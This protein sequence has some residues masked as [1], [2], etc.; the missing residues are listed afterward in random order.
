MSKNILGESTSP[1]LIQHKDNPVHWQ[2][3]GAEALAMAKAKD[4]PILLSV[5]YAACHWCHVMAHESFEDDETAKLMNQLF[6]NIKVD[7]E[8]RPDIDT[9]YMSAL[10]MLGQRGGWP[11]TMFLTPDGDP[12]W[13][14]T[15]FPKEPRYGMPSFKEVLTQIHNAYRTSPQNIRK[16]TEA[17]RNGLEQEARKETPGQLSSQI[18]DAAAE[19]LITMIDMEL[20]GLK[21]AP[22]FPQTALL[23]L[24]WRA[25]LRT[26]NETYRA[27]VEI[28]LNAMCQG[29]IY[30]HLGGGWA[31]YSV[32]ERWLAPHFEKM[33][34]D[35][36]LLIQLLTQVWRHNQSPLYEQRIAETVDWLKREMIASNGGFAASLDA[37]SE[38]EEGKFYVWS[39]AELDRL[40]PAESQTLF[41]QTYDVSDGGNWEDTNILN[42]LLS[43]LPLTDAE[44]D[45][46]HACRQ[47]LLEHRSHR[48]RPGWDD[49]VLADWNGLMISA[50]TSAGMAFDR[51]DWVDLART[52]YEAVCS[53][54]GFT[55]DGE[56]RL[57]HS[58]RDGQAQ[59]SA[60]SEDHANMAHAA[61]LLFEATQESQY[62]KKAEA[63]V[64]TLNTHY[65]A[66]DAGG[67]YLTADDAEALI[68]RT[69]TADDDATPNANGTMV[70]VLT[71]LGHIT[72]NA[73]YAV[74][75]D[76]ILHSFGGAVQ[77]NF[78]QLGTLLNNFEF[79]TSTAQIVICGNKDDDQ[80]QTFLRTVHGFSIPN[81][82]LLLIPPGTQVPDHHPATGK[83][84]IDGM[85]TAY[86]C[87]GQTCSLPCTDVASLTDNLECNFK[88]KA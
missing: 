64:E 63:W 40:L 85:P 45:S 8:E 19:K 6:V 55:K 34:Y 70:D 88:Q 72:G 29:G 75:A 2:V 66:G 87:I 14:G 52:A 69:R 77:T 38:G 61:L 36:A 57:Y 79:Y 30:D 21:G 46:L 24:L 43:P 53:T 58:A 9:I 82:L 60:T 27:G 80:V 15:Y 62:L 22:K 33:L 23:E 48:E 35:N 65:W 51:D 11:L 13:G 42:R 39:K 44:E 74:R 20:G 76:T 81:Q 7:R 56:E 84:M 3:W 73:S 5:G 71:R 50:L 18:L 16:N 12:F 25:Y 17:L 4:K 83:G 47:L 1:Y 31:R 67:Y 32:D 37:D 10:H 41:H 78:F 54:M 49:K 68:V 28:S 86:I 59:H 26:G